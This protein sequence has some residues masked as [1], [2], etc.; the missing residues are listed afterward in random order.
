M[1]RNFGVDPCVLADL[2]IPKVSGDLFTYRP[3]RST[4]VNSDML[5][6]Y[7]EDLT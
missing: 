3:S 4:R 2:D 6:K 5:K 1:S 7:E